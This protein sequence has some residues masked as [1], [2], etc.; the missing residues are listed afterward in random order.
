MCSEIIIREGRLEDASLIAEVQIK[1]WRH[2]YKGIIDQ[3]YL[4]EGLDRD[5]RMK[6]W[7]ETLARRTEGMFLA[8]EGAV[9]AGFALVEESRDVR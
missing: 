3:A 9:L 8:F 7:Q 6:V 1:S 4:D 5:V 2:V